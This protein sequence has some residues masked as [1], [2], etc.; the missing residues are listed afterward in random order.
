MD[1]KDDPDE[2]NSTSTDA[3]YSSP[4]LVLQETNSLN[5]TELAHPPSIHGV[6]LWQFSLE[7]E[8]QSSVQ[9]SPSTHSKRVFSNIKALFDPLTR[10]FKFQGLEAVAFVAYFAAVTSVSSEEYLDHFGEEKDISLARSKRYTKK[11]LARAD[12]LKSL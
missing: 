9:D 5:D 3:A 4:D 12:C 11:V 8:N 1:D 10:P 2:A 7:E 6:V